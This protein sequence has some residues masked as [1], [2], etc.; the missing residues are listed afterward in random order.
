MSGTSAGAKYNML[1][2]LQAASRLLIRASLALFTGVVLLLI[3]SAFWSNRVSAW[4]QAI[5]FA[6]ALLS[7]FRP[8]YGLLALAALA[9][10]GQV[11]SR[12]LDS[13]MRGA[14]AL[15]LAFLAGALV[16]GWTLRE[17]RTFP[18][19]R[20]DIAALMFGF[21]VVASCLEQMWFLQIQMD[22]AW[23]F[24]QEILSY[25]SRNYVTSARGFGMLPRA[26]WLLEGMA[27]LVYV[28]RYARTSADF[29]RHL[30][31]MLVVGAVATAVLTLVAV[32]GDFAATRQPEISVLDFFARGRWSGHI[33][34]VNA[35]GSYFAMMAFLA[36]G[37][38]LNDREWR[39]AW[40][41]TGGVLLLTMLMTGSRTAVAAAGLVGVLVFARVAI[42]YSSYLV[43]AV[44]A[45]CVVLA[46]GTALYLVFRTTGA[47]PSE[48]VSIR[49]A[50]LQTTASML[51][52]EPAFGVGI[53][54]YSLWS[55]HYAPPELFKI[56]RPDNAHN[57]LAQIAGELGLVGLITF[58]IVLVVSF[59][60]RSN[61][62]AA[63]V[64][65]GPLIA[66]LSVFILTWLGGHPLLVGESAYPFWITLGVVATV[67][68]SDFKA[69]P[70]VAIIG[71]AAVLLLVSIPFRVDS[72][73]AQLDLAR[74][75][76]GVSARQ[77]MT[78]RARF[79]VPAGESRVEFPLRAR[80]ASD[81]EPVEI[82][83]L[84]DGSASDTITL[85]DR[86]WR[87]T[88]VNLSGD[89][90]RRFHQIDLR[91]R[92]D[93]LDNLDPGRSSVEVG[94]WEIIPKPNG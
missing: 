29:T 59:R 56:W 39:S 5:I 13:Q 53:G 8:Q 57:N 14:E 1:N 72:K 10:L 74:V 24:A 18:S 48:A 12:T 3:Q 35:A 76:Y 7:Y 65:R 43:R 30:V 68:A 6:T 51:F 64:M 38:G 80:S 23:P 91:I 11:G 81:N 92:P 61:V 94:K 54:Q 21:V 25:A 37:L 90:S 44:S 70:W 34:D 27:L 78:S 52:A 42:S 82:D 86:N 79:F 19:T 17:L 63:N 60:T 75:S 50:F 55:A 2:R 33:S 88:P 77:L 22:F 36:L 73:S 31:I 83:V 28:L 45:A 9:P 87:R 84:V 71:I 85:T 89:S 46:V 58:V 26:M 41:A 49:W 15:V 93:T 16:R 66:G 69:N 67:I 40:L 47:T 20:L 4:M 32:A 62:P